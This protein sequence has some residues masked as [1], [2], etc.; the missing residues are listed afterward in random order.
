MCWI[1]TILQHT[2]NYSTRNYSLHMY[3]NIY[4]YNISISACSQPSNSSKCISH[5]QPKATV[6]QLLFASFLKKQKIADSNI[7]YRFFVFASRSAQGPWTPLDPEY[8]HDERLTIQLESQLATAI[9][10]GMVTPAIV[11]SVRFSGAI[12]SWAVSFV[13]QKDGIVC[14]CLNILNVI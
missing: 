11:T 3:I 10:M 6:Q 2:T 4:I 7:Y 5:C 9:P 1:E 8:N 14:N 12:A 13:W